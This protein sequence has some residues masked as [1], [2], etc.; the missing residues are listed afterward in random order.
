M[1]YTFRCTACSHEWDASM[2]MADRD[3][4]LSQPCI[5]CVATGEGTVKRIISIAPRISYD[6]SQTILQR[7]GS[8]WNDVLKKIQK[9]SGRY[10]KKTMETR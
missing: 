10:A 6:G 1:T 7:A 9:G 5:K 2:S 4:P 3:V 8:G